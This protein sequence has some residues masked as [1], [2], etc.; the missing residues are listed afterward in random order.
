MRKSNAFESIGQTFHF[1]D[2]QQLVRGGPDFPKSATGMAPTDVQ[3]LK[4]HQ[5]FKG[6]KTTGKRQS[7]VTNFSTT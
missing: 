3:L 5:M 7:C 6:E 4:S 2:K 1:Q